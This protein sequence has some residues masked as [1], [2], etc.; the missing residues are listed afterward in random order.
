MSAGR[1][2]SLIE[3]DERAKAEARAAALRSMNESNAQTQQGAQNS[4]GLNL[5]PQL[6]NQ[7]GG[8]MGAMF[9]GNA[10]GGEAA[11]ASTGGAEGV[12]GGSMGQGAGLAASEAGMGSAAGGAGGGSSMGSMAAAAGPWAALVAAIGVNEYNA[13]GHRR[14]GKDYAKDLGT[15]EVFH[16]DM[17]ERWMPKLGMKEGSKANALASHLANPVNPLNPKKTWERFK[18]L[19]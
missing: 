2:D 9:G 1:R 15:G 10:G 8:K 17:E 19:F 13:K 14:K 12:A 6:M 11:L 16:Q 3:D 4:G 7:L 5:N 18:K